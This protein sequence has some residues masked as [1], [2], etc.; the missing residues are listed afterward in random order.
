LST[1]AA[2]EALFM[3]PPWQIFLTFPGIRCM[4]AVRLQW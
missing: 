2:A 4:F 1:G 3:L